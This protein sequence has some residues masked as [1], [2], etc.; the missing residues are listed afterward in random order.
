VDARGH[1]PVAQVLSLVMIGDRTS[2]SLAELAGID[3]TPVAAIEDFK[4]A[5]G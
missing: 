2:V 4:A 1:S 5:L 3:P